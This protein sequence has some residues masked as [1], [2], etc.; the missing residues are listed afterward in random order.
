MSDI[1]LGTTIW[2]NLTDMTLSERNQTQ[3]KHTLFF[4]SDKEQKLEDLTDAAR[5]QVVIGPASS[6]AKH[7]EGHKAQ[8]RGIGVL[9]LD[10]RTCS[11]CKKKITKPKY[12]LFCMHVVL[13]FLKSVSM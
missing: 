6:T 5:S 12:I 13:Q 1:L 11:V 8:F 4:H 10:A 3:S 2:V 7:T 9:F